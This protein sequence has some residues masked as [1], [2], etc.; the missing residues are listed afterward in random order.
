MDKRILLGR[1]AMRGALDVRKR[2]EVSYDS[3]ICIYDVAE[4]LGISVW[5]KGGGSFG[6]MFS[7]TNQAILVPSLRPAPRQSYTCAHEI[8]HWYYDH[9][10]KLDV[11]EERDTCNTYDDDEFLADLFAG[12][13]LMPSN[14]VSRAFKRRSLSPNS[15][16]EIDFYRITCQL[17]VGYITLLSHM[18]WTQQ[19]INR[20]RF[21]SLNRHTPKSI[22]RSVLGDTAEDPGHLIIA[23]QEWESI[24][25]DLQIGQM[26]LLPANTT[27]DERHAAIIQS[28]SN[29]VLVQ[30]IS[31]GILQA[32]STTSPWASFIRISRKDF[33]GRGIYRHLEEA[34]D[35]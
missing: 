28:G 9:G 34:D 2:V 33:E 11:Y 22:R 10:S 12:H 13:L 14:A 18:F 26:A 35:E 24:A 29:G 4:R 31:P 6:G 16:S 1:K 23:D 25:I 8:G 30:A 19:S 27:I 15:C 3:P 17:G 21:D 32:H 20:T 7:K 5:F